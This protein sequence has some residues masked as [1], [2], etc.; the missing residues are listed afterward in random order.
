MNKQ[1][2]L[3]HESLKSVLDYNIHSG[4]FTWKPRVL[5]EFKDSRS[6]R[7]WNTRYAGQIAGTK[8]G[9]R[10]EIRIKVCGG[11]TVRYKAH[12]LAWFYVTGEWPETGFVVDHINGDATDN[13]FINLRV[14]TVT[15]NNRNKVMQSNNTSGR[16][17]V[18]K[19][20][21]SG[22]WVAQGVT[23]GRNFFLGYADCF[24]VACGIREAWERQEENYTERN[25]SAT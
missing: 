7:V 24:E 12:R 3:S 18:Y 22:K 8:T 17:G 21:N 13:R 11:H 25:G 15:V 23:G 1:E 4:A 16:V 20:K 9:G 10:I 6:C 14:V 5:T 2:S 19:D